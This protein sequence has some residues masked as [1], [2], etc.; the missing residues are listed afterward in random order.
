MSQAS[1]ALRKNFGD[2][3]AARDCGLTTPE[4]VLRYDDILYGSDPAWQALDVY[5]PRAAEGEVLPVI[6]SVHGGG[7]VYG[8]KEVYQY[9]CMSL[10]QRG[11]AVVNFTYR[12]APEFLYPSALE[13][14]NLVFSWV[15]ENAEQYGFDPENIF[16]VGDSAGAHYLGMYCNLCTNPAYTAETSFTTPAGFAPS[17][18]ALNC[19]EYELRAVQEDDLAELT[20]A[21]MGDLLPGKGTEEELAR[22][23]VLD[24]VTPAFPPTFVM[25]ATGDFLRPQAGPLAQMLLEK[26]VPFV[27]RFYGDAGREPL[28]HVFHLNVRSADAQL[29]NQEECGFFRQ[30]LR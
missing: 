14:T 13:D 19:G 26:S 30:F 7:W 6:V 11:F 15:L 10:A 21:L 20:R 22:L 17:A 25:T 29:C 3:D 28:G 27:Y 4:D 23:S 12:L 9:Y 1:D 24:A 2:G 5:R 16:A 18:V 8:N